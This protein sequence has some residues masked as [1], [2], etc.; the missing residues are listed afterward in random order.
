[1][2]RMPMLPAALCL[3]IAASAQAGT[4]TPLVIYGDDDYPPYSYVENG[5][6]KGIYTQIVREALQAM[7]QYAVQLRPVPWKRGLLM[8]QTGE[9]FAL[10]PPYSWRSERPYVRYSVPLLM[11][12]L[13]LLC[14]QDVLARRTLRQ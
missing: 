4:A 9:A 5:Q 6:L 7:P 10:Y 8:L 2:L 3:F 13:V 1:M 11:E 12:Q 14:N